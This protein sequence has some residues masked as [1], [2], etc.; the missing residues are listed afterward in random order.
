MSEPDRPTEII[1]IEKEEGKLLHPDQQDALE[2]KYLDGKTEEEIAKEMG[3]TRRTLIRVL[4]AGI[5]K[6]QNLVKK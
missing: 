5:E 4:K 6:L 3:L 1:V 2:K